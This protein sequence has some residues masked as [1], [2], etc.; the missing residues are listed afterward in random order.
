MS[1]AAPR[2]VIESAIKNGALKASKSSFNMTQDLSAFRK[3]PEYL[4]TVKIAEEIAQKIKPAP[5]HLERGLHKTLKDASARSNGPR[6]IEMKT[7][8][9]VDVVVSYENGAPRA[10]IEV[11]HPVNAAVKALYEK[12]VSRISRAVAASKKKGGTIKFGYF[13]FTVFAHAPKTVDMKPARKSVRQRAERI[14]WAAKKVVSKFAC[15]AK[16]EVGRIRGL[17]DGSAWTVC[18]LTIAP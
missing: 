4:L 2:P 3:A 6:S 16:L 14:F 11:K 7:N 12:D 17:S 13:V 10:L 8:A 9:R 1:K 5:I 15:K 18:I